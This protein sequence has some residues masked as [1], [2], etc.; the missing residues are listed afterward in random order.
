MEGSGDRIP[1]AG[2]PEFM[3]VDQPFHISHGWLND[4]LF[5]KYPK[6][7]AYF[8]LSIDGNLIEHTAISDCP[9]EWVEVPGNCE[10]YLYDFPEGIRT[11]YPDIEEGTQVHFEGFWMGPCTFMDQ[12]PDLLEPFE[13]PYE[14]LGEIVV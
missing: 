14:R 5:T 10:L 7:S 4:K 9:P 12:T 1:L 11:I 2:L 6:G 13:C 3:D 8:L